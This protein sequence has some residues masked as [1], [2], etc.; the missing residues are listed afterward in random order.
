MCMLIR[1]TT[2]IA[3][4]ASIA[5]VTTLGD[6]L[7]AIPGVP[8]HEQDSVCSCGFSHA[9]PVQESNQE[10]YPDSDSDDCLVCRFLAQSF[11]QVEL[12][13]VSQSQ[14]NE[15]YQPTCSVASLPAPVSE[16]SVIGCP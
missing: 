13:E 2:S 6:G 10:D 7:H 14:R 1:K 5:L 9:V 12:F 3:L 15:F 16:N 11:E 8:Q 4:L